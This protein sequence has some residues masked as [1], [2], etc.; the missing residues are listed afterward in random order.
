M[1]TIVIA[2]CAAMM[3]LLVSGVQGWRW[4]AEMRSGVTANWDVYC[5]ERRM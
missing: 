1:K 2:T 3:G 4:M 5:F